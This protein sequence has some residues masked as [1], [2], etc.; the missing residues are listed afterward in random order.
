MIIT[1]ELLISKKACAGQVRL[2]EEVFL[3]G[4][5][6]TRDEM[7]ALAR[8][9]YDKFEFNWAV[10]N[11]LDEAHAKAY[12][13]GI[14]PHL[15][16]YDEAIASHKKAYNEAIAPHWEAYKEAIA[17]AFVNCWFEQNS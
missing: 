5:P 12:I 1:K 16:A 6:N 13:E 15:K 3:N 10:E 4:T 11:L 8:K 14:A 7:I 17:I 9:Y 2:F